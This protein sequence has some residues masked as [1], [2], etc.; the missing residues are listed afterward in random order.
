[1]LEQ[2]S[3]GPLL[4]LL[5]DKASPEMYAQVDTVTAFR[6]LVG[7]YE[8]EIARALRSDSLRAIYGVDF[9]K[10]AVHC[11]DLAEDGELECLHFF[12]TLSAV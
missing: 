4:A 7:P 1:M 3:C 6:A 5:I 8:P 11:T 9:A 10:N 2:V 12:E